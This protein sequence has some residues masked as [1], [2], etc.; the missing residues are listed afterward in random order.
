MEQLHNRNMSV[1]DLIHW[2]VNKF[3]DLKHA[4]IGSLVYF[5]YIYFIE[6]KHIKEAL[7]SFFVGTVFAIYLSPVFSGWTGL[8]I[9]V[10]SFLTGV[11]GMKL[12]EALLKLDYKSILKSLVGVKEETPTEN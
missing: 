5:L 7:V 1:Q 10:T 11:L 9:E 12:T 4:M 2:F 8:E 6:K 3:H